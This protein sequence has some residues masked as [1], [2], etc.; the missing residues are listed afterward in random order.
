MSKNG[1]FNF[2]YKSSVIEKNYNE[3]NLLVIKADSFS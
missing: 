1:I 2:E 3:A